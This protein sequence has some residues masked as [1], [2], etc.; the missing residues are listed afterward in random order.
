MAAA[1]ENNLS[2]VDSLVDEPVKKTGRRASSMAADVFNI[3]DLGKHPIVGVMRV[4]ALVSEGY[5]GLT[6]TIEKEGTKL[7]IAPE[8]QK[9]NW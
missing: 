3:Q 6:M 9:L 5:V 1:T 4:I 8:T 2:K 7:L